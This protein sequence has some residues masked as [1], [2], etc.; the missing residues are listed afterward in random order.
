MERFRC[1]DN[2]GGW[3]HGSDVLLEKKEESL[4]GEIDLPHY[5]NEERAFCFNF[6]LNADNS[7]FQSMAVTV[8]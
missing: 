6:V 8:L 4:L 2:F 7:F 1:G 5:L 3:L